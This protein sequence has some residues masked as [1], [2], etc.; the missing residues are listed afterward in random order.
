MMGK[1]LVAAQN[2]GEIRALFLG[3]GM[4]ACSVLMYFFIGTTIVPK[5]KRSIWTKESICKL[6]KASIKEK[7]YCIFNKDSGEE[8]IFRYP[9]LVVQVNLTA[10]GQMAMLYH[11]EDTWIRNPKCS[12]I[13]GNLENYTQVEKE[14]ESVKKKFTK[15][16]PYWL[17]LPDLM[18][19]L[20]AL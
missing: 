2:R 5:Y 18:S 8:N 14:V 6:M 12:Y 17:P 20:Q 1:K 13:P 15:A 19:H 10:F 9:C 3:L 4:L 11:K 7:V 16:H